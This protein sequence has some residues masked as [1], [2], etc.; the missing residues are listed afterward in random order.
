MGVP[1]VV[2]EGVRVFEQGFIGR[3]TGAQ[4]EALLHGG[5]G[6]PAQ[7]DAEAGLLQ[8][9]EHLAGDVLGVEE[10]DEQAVDAVFDDFFHRRRVARD[11]E[12]TGGHG[13]EHGPA[14][15]EGHGEVDVGGGD[16]QDLLVLLVGDAAEEMGAGG[17]DAALVEHHGAPVGG[18]R[19]A[20]G[21]GAFAVADV[22]AA[23]DQGLGGGVFALDDFQ[24]AHEL[25]EAA[26]GLEV[27][28]DIG[29]DGVAGFE[30]EGVGCGG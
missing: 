21:R 22:V 1:Q 29:D 7:G 5:A 11:D 4:V 30:G 25:V 3:D 10:V 8:A 20:G 12:A 26:V 14:E 18:R 24:G 19:A 6:G 27:A 16:L 28:G 15:H 17:V 23:D 2:I 9:V 13:F